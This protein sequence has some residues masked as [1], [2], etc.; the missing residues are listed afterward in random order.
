[1]AVTATARELVLGAHPPRAD[2]ER[3][4]QALLTGTRELVLAGEVSPTVAQIAEQ[5]GVGIGTFYRRAVRKEAL[6]AAVLVDLLD[7]I[8]ADATKATTASSWQAFK[9]FAAGYIETRQVTC[10]ISHALEAEFDGAVAAAMGRTRAA[11]TELTDRLHRA[12]L[13]DDEVTAEDLI[14]LLASIEV[15]DTTL[16]L[17]PD[18][19]RQRRVL[20]RI[21]NSLRPADGQ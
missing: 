3:N 18:Q 17:L 21:L 8:S 1:M 12:G 9:R 16:G 6:L 10:S 7:E 20:A 13:L 14:T 19:Q 15:T 4:V 2:A 11:F 5:A